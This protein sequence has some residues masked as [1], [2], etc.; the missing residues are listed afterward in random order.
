MPS[1]V[2]EQMRMNALPVLW[3]SDNLEHV[4][5]NCY[6]SLDNGCDQHA[7]YRRIH[8][9]NITY[10]YCNYLVAAMH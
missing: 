7:M 5:Q 4:K 6:S 2:N 1:N 9:R 8:M 3:Q 10:P